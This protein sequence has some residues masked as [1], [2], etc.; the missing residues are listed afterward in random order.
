MA[1]TGQTD[2]A[3]VFAALGDDTRLALGSRLAEGGQLSIAHLTS[4]TGQTRQSVTKHL[5]VLAGA[6]LVRDSHAGRERL[7]ELEPAHLED[8]LRFLESVARRWD[9]VLARRPPPKPTRD[10]AGQPGWPSLIALMRKNG[11]VMPQGLSRISKA[12]R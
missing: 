4:G 11:C 8:S 2:P 12:A 3:S 7:S 9:D 6:G 10:P 5:L 1:T